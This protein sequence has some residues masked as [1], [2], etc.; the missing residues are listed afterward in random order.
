MKKLVLILL[1]ASGCANQGGHPSNSRMIAFGDSYTVGEGVTGYAILTANYLGRQ[2]VDLGIHGVSLT[3]DIET[4]TVQT[5][6]YQP[7]DIIIL[8]TCLN[9]MR[10]H[11]TDLDHLRQYANQLA[12]DIEFIAPKVS[13]LFIGSCV[14][15]VNGKPGSNQGYASNDPN[16][17]HGSDE[18]VDM[19]NQTIVEVINTLGRVNVYFVD[20]VNYFKPSLTETLMLDT[21]HP[22]NLGHQQIAEGFIYGITKELSGLRENIQ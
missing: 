12:Q 8:R 14:Y 10:Q 13:R 1:L 18:A 11:G 5:T 3:D 9:D 22:N 16:W 20:D 7:T 17:A 6:E 4:Q 21:V 2:L 19:Y 15:M